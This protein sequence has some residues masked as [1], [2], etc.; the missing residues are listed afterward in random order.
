MEARKKAE[1]VEMQTGAKDQIVEYYFYQDY[2][3]V[4]HNRRQ[5]LASPLALS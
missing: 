5:I 1:K 2:K 4:L 3:I